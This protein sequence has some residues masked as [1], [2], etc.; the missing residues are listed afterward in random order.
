MTRFML[1][2]PD[3]AES[4][5]IP[6]TP[7]PL[8]KDLHDVLTLHPQLLPAE[9]LGLGQTVVVGRESSLT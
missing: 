9:D 8:E 7:L 6:E 2:R 3:D 4:Q 1:M 5:L